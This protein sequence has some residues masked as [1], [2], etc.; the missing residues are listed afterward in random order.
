MA[1]VVWTRRETIIKDL[2]I[3]EFDRNMISNKT[4]W[5]NLINVTDPT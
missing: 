2:G 4:L 3:N 1:Y 5:Y